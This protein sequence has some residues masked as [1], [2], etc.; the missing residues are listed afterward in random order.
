MPKRPK[1]ELHL[2]S[3]ES[4]YS[5]DDENDNESLNQ[6]LA[7]SSGGRLHTRNSLGLKY[8][9]VVTSPHHHDSRSRYKLHSQ[10]KPGA[11]KVKTSIQ[12]PEP[13]LQSGNKGRGVK[14]NS[15][16][17]FQTGAM[18]NKKETESLRPPPAGR[19]PSI[20]KT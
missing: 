11:P 12:S 3:A 15:S 14:V 7:A 8:A 4:S 10:S 20:G 18:K 2:T 17:Q 5:D 6:D 1:L 13:L 19:L 9:S 16:L